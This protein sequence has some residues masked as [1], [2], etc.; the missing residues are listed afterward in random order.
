MEFLEN[1]RAFVWKIP[2]K[3]FRRFFR[4]YVAKPNS[5]PNPPVAVFSVNVVRQLLSLKRMDFV[6]VRRMPGR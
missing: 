4:N 2:D 1:F 3:I 5:R 6:L